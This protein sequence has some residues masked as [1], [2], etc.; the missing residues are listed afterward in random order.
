MGPTIAERLMA[1]Y[2]PE[3]LAA[4]SPWFGNAPAGVAK[5]GKGQTGT[6]PPESDI[7]DLTYHD[8]LCSPEILNTDAAA[9]VC[10]PFRKIS[11]DLDKAIIWLRTSLLLAGVLPP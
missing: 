11:S 4:R 9:K 5:Y 8:G 2:Y 7:T 1:S 3:P 10:H 6:D